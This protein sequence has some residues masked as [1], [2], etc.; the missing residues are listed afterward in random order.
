MT[1]KEL[2]RAMNAYVDALIGC[3]T[4]LMSILDHMAHHEHSAPD[5][6]P[7]PVVLANLLDDTL[8]H[9]RSIHPQDLEP[10][11]A[12]LRATARTIEEEIYLVND[13]PPDPPATNG[14]DR[15]H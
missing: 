3:S 1:N 12:A 5:A 4:Q 7:P 8:H 11:A 9:A 13:D 15:L 10:A 6:P 14:S 2:R